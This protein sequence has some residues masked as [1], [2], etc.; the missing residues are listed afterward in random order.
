MADIDTNLIDI[1]FTRSH[2]L[3]EM[4]RAE[5]CSVLYSLIATY[6][7]AKGYL[8]EAHWNSEGTSFN[9]MHKIFDKGVKLLDSFIDAL[10]ER[11]RSF[12]AYAMANLNY[13]KGSTLLIPYSLCH[14]MDG[15][16]EDVVSILKTISNYL[17]MFI[18][19]LD[20]VD[21]VTSNVLQEHVLEVD[22]FIYLIQSNIV[23]KVES[24][25]EIESD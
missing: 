22:K 25:V 14:C 2:H 23:I 21:K 24:E 9:S 12:G 4:S 17:Y 7:D 18:D 16:T 5:V 11:I 6:I 15:N 13:A 1:K 10:G 8:L 19:S 20:K 3:S